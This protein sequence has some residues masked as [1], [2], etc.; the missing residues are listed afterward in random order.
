M[1]WVKR[2]ADKRL[3]KCECEPPMYQPQRWVRNP[4]TQEYQRIIVGRRKPEG[5]LGDLWQCDQCGT[6]WRVGL[7]S[8]PTVKTNRPIN[9]MTEPG[10]VRA[11]W[12][13]QRRYRRY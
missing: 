4:S 13:T 2:A 1:P 10:W 11:G 5:A 9:R 3:A 8:V 12:F 6:V 7:V